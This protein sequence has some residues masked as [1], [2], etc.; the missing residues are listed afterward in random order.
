[1]SELKETPV[2]TPNFDTCF[3]HSKVR[4]CFAKMGKRK[5]NP[6]WRP[7]PKVQFLLEKLRTRFGKP[8]C[9]KQCLQSV[10]PDFM[11]LAAQWQLSWIV[12]PA[13]DKR[14]ALLAHIKRCRG[15]SQA[16]EH[17]TCVRGERTSLVMTA[18]P[19][20]KKYNHQ[21]LGVSLCRE[22]FKGCTGVSSKFLD[23]AQSRARLG[24][25]S[26]HVKK[27][28]RVRPRTSEMY[29]AIWALIKDLH[30]QSPF[31]GRSTSAGPSRVRDDKWHIPFHHKVG[32][33]R[34][35]LKLY[36]GVSD[37]PGVHIFTK[38]PKYSTFKKV[39]LL[40]EIRNKVVFHRIVDI[41]RCPKCEYFEWKC[42]SVPLALRGIWQEA[43]AKHRLIEVEQKRC[44]MADRAKAAA[45]FPHV[46]LYMVFIGKVISY[47]ARPRFNPM[48]VIACSQRPPWVF[49]DVRGVPSGVF[50][51]V[52]GVPRCPW[53][54][55]RL[56]VAAVGSLCS[57]TS[58]PLIGKAPTR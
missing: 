57:R 34:L 3:K 56:I 14:A 2:Y 47:S 1:M 35:V 48:R 42:S 26:W 54:L 22:A 53:C 17:G 55:R 6:K 21:F 18:D 24:A 7:L 40:P 52:R 31:A 5:K 25:D 20:S 44:Y 16:V 43:L 37:V 41:G 11:Q 45:A 19:K 49:R 36:N 30:L 38:K 4:V 39:M 33:W 12:T 51:E 29:E 10:G 28:E 8:C 50:R 9:K 27:P 46:E 23:S 32:L 15:A 58:Q 13:S